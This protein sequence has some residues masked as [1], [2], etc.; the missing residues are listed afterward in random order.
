MTHNSPLVIGLAKL[1][2][3]HRYIIF[4]RINDFRMKLCNISRVSHVESHPDSGPAF[5]DHKNG[6]CTNDMLRSVGLAW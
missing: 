6:D 3:N 1:A 4:I 2:I 5:V